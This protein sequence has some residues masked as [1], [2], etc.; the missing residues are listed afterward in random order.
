MSN[1]MGQ[2]FETA[3]GVNSVA[4]ILNVSDRATE[5]TLLESLARK[6]PN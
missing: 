3:G 6:T 1:L 4:E 2:S 5:R